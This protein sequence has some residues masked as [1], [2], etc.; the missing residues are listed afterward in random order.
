MALAVLRCLAK[1]GFEAAAFDADPA[2]TRPAA[3]ASSAAEVG[4]RYVGAG[5][6]PE[7]YACPTGEDVALEGMEAG[8]C[9]AVRSTASVGGARDPARICADRGVGFFHAPIVRERRTKGSCFAGRRSRRR[10]GAVAPGT[11]R[12]DIEHVAGH[13]QVAK[14]TNDCLPWAN[15]R[16]PNEASRVRRRDRPP[17]AA[18]GAH[19]ERRRLRRATARRLPR[20]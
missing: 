4:R 16:A 2:R 14:M 19:D 3:E 1:H 5:F 6:E 12:S 20:R 9:V 15:G 8:D 10:H 7:V 13:G 11:F 17:E 18:Q